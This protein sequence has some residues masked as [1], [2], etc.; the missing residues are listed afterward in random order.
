M[1]ERIPDGLREM[2]AQA[3]GA[4]HLQWRTLLKPGDWLLRVCAAALVAA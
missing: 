2:L 4:G 3:T 1:N